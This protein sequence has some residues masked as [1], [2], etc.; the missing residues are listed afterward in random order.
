MNVSSSCAFAH[1]RASARIRLAGFVHV[2]HAVLVLAN[3][4]VDVRI[5]RLL[6]HRTRAD[7]EINRV[8]RRAIDQAMTVD[9]TGLESRC[10]AGLENRLAFV[11]AQDERALDD[12]DELIL[13][14]VP[15]AL[16]GLR[17][18]LQSGQADPELIEADRIAEPLAQTACDDPSKRLRIA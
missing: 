14:G 17:A 8:P 10:F 9:D 5:F 4:Q 16:R 3:A 1:Q 2:D 12:I 7:L 13:G 18:P 6:A 11:L 15:A